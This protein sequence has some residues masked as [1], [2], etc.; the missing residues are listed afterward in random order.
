ML[1]RRP[2][3]LPT[4]LLLLCALGAGASHA[5]DGQD[6][7]L[8][9]LEDLMAVQVTGVT[10]RAEPLG[11]TPAA[12]YVLSAEDIRRSGARSI[13]EALRLVPGLDV[14]R[15]NTSSYAISARGFN[16]SSSDKLQVLLDGR[17]V[18][19]PLFSGVFWDVLDT[20]LPD[21]ERIEVI[22]GPGGA[23][24]GANA[25]NGVINIITKTAADTQGSQ[26]LLAAGTEQKHEAAFRSGGRFGDT[27]RVRV[28][29]Q[30]RE[31]DSSRM[32]GGG[33]GPDGQ[34]LQQAGFRLG[35]GQVEAG[36]FTVSGDLYDG[37]NLDANGVTE[38]DGGNLV[39]HWKR[40]W[41]GGAETSGQLSL[42]S[43]HRRIPGIYIEQRRTY[44]A[45][46]QHSLTAIS[47]N[48]LTFGLS[49]QLTEDETGGPPVA[50]I[51]TPADQSLTTYGG[52]VQDEIALD[53]G[54]GSLVLG[55]KVEHNEYTGV[56]FQP[57]VRAG[58]RLN[59][60][61]YSWGSVARAVRTPNRLNRELG[62]F[63]SPVFAGA[64][65]CTEGDT[66]LL[67]NPDFD[68]EQLVAYETG[69]R[70]R[71]G[72]RLLVELT[73]YFNDYTELSSF[74]GVGINGRYANNFDGQGIGTEINASWTP[75]DTVQLSAYYSYL[76]LDLKRQGGSADTTTEATVEGNSPANQAG[77]RANWQ[78]GPAWNLGGQLRYVDALARQ[79][80]PSYAELDLR[81][82]WWLRPELELALVGQ[83]LL[84]RSHA[85]FGLPSARLEVERAVLAELRWSWQ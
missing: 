14:A 49:A 84:Q 16:S 66:L 28:Y 47:G 62:F 55:T 45:D 37:Q 60:S 26:L 6:L 77:L 41:Q 23:V 9:G 53:G 7:S 48:L 61:W 43:Y 12:V 64:L 24:W 63:C 2:L 76:E 46:L 57:S 72:P 1:N 70:W 74:E 33:Q 13:P 5:D 21:I 65:G 82:G 36:K 20:Y 15:I 17:S 40:A 34:N 81:A 78:P 27:G 79:Q 11:R 42:D 73:G 75:T 58:W 32:A 85:E 35:W 71:A 83:N 39:G 8:L 18:Y 19:T 22:R 38:V 68:S 10:R 50:I 30:S 67:G 54:Q 69:L 52:F 44:A 51:F 56:E 29:A 31:L 3:N 59:D 25:V 80:V 4:K